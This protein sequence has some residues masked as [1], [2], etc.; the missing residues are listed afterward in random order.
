M[1]KKIMITKRDIEILNYVNRFG[2]VTSDEVRMFIGKSIITTRKVIKKLK[3]RG[4]LKSDKIFHNQNEIITCTEIGA[5]MTSYRTPAEI[6]LSQ[7]EHDLLVGKMYHSMCRRITHEKF[8]TDRDMK[9]LEKFREHRPDIVF[10]N[11]QLYTAVEIELHKKADT[12]MLEIRKFY[13]YEDQFEKVVYLVQDERLEHYLANFFSLYPK[14]EVINI[15]TL[16][17]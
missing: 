10:E 12:R 2:K 9:I 13:E 5:E 3:D 7:I 1:P 15:K 11:L 14:F 4:Y 8:Y 6:K 17:N 16:N